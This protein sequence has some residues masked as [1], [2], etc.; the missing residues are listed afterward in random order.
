MQSHRIWLFA[1]GEGEAMPITY[2]IDPERNLVT[3]EASGVLKE[4][5]YLEARV[6]LAHD[7]QLRP[8]M[9]QLMDF[10]MVE[11]HELTPHLYSSF[12]NQEKSLEP[13]FGDYRL[14]VVTSSDLHFGFT[15]MFMVE[16]DN[17]QSNMGVFRD[18]D[19]ARAWLFDE[20]QQA[21]SDT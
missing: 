5:D 14:A 2:S 13:Q 15:R 6:R 16:M 12:I 20:S 3:V 9:M 18:M 11:R 17:F 4:A 8:G 7:P 10:R 1:S 19:E 21:E